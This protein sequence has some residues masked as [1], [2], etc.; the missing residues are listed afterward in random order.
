MRKPSVK[1]GPRSTPPARLL[2]LAWLGYAL[3]AGAQA[4]ADSV[5]E[6]EAVAKPEAATP[7]PEPAGDVPATAAGDGVERGRVSWYGSR[8]AGHRTACGVRFDPKQLTMAHP[9]LPC[10]TQ[11]RVTNPANHRSIVVVVNDRGPF[12]GGR[13]GD[14]SRSAAR[15]LGIS[16]RGEA[17]VE[18]TAI[19]VGDPP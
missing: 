12:T 11:V 2:C 15:R 7:A 10:G 14:V 5:A 16:R 1:S 3:V 9:S 19:G 8:F 13:I 4:D 6:P 17:D 18:I